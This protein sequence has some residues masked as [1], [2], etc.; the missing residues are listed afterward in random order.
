VR[1]VE[2]EAERPASDRDRDD[3]NAHELL[4]LDRLAGMPKFVG[5]QRQS[6]AGQVDDLVERAE[7]V[8]T[9]QAPAID[10]NQLGELGGSQSHIVAGDVEL[11]IGKRKGASFAEAGRSA[12]VMHLQAVGEFEEQV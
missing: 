9:K 10:T 8:R 7:Q 2:E 4:Q 11:L 6:A 1:R 12:G 3:G 5:I